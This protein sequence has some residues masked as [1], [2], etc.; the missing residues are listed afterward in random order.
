MPYSGGPDTSVPQPEERAD[1]PVPFDVTLA[2]AVTAEDFATIPAG[3][4]GHSIDLINLGPGNVWI[5]NDTDASPTTGI[6]VKKNE[7]YFA[8]ALKVTARWSFI[9]AAGQTPHIRG[10]VWAG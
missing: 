2:T 8:S 7:A 3:K 10:V 9:G 5:R 4:I 1:T 6:L